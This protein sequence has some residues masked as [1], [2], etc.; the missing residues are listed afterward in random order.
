MFGGTADQHV[1]IVAAEVSTCRASFDTKRK[2]RERGSTNW[3]AGDAIFRVDRIKDGSEERRRGLKGPESEGG[4]KPQEGSLGRKKG[5]SH[6]KGVILCFPNARPSCDTG[7]GKV[8]RNGRDSEK[9]NTWFMV[10]FFRRHLW[11]QY[12]LESEPRGFNTY[13]DLTEPPRDGAIF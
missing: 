8:D 11:K 2:T 4:V 7:V 9:A 13:I 6:N 12:P 10:L 3:P 5:E 1:N